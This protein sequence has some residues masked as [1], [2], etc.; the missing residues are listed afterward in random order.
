MVSQKQLNTS[1][2]MIPKYLVEYSTGNHASSRS[3]SRYSTDDPITYGQFLKEL[4]DCGAKIEALKHEG[5]DLPRVDFD[6][7]IKNAAGTL[8]AE[9][10]CAS[11]GIKPEE[12]RYRFGFTA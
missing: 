4:L 8:A 10:I 9:H 12:E 6:K 3:T 2:P 5:V 11:L 7:L 1:K